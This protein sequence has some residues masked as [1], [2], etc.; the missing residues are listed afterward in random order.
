MNAHNLAEL[1][2]LT[3][4]QMNSL[5]SGF[6]TQRCKDYDD[7]KKC[8]KGMTELLTSQTSFC[9]AQRYLY[10]SKSVLFRP[11][12]AL[13]WTGELCEHAHGSKQLRAEAAVQAGKLSKDY[14]TALCDMWC[15]GSP[16]TYG[17][18]CFSAHGVADMR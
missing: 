15:L 7:S 2:V 9:L 8:P 11:H 18:Q 6:K 3:A 17:D 1:R 4:I 5:V 10:V 14:K 13:C 16:C 12:N